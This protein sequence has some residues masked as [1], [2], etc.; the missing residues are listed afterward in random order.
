MNKRTA[1]IV[2]LIS[3]MLIFCLAGCSEDGAPV[4]NGDPNNELKIEF[5]RTV[6]D[7]SECRES[8]AVKVTNTSELA[9]TDVMLDVIPY[10]ADGNI[11]EFGEDDPGTED[12]RIGK[13]T[14]TLSIDCIMPGE[15]TG[16]FD[17]GFYELKNV[18]DHID[19]QLMSVSWRDPDKIEGGDVI[20]EDYSYSIGSEEICLTLK[21]ET[22]YDYDINDPLGKHTLNVIIIAFDEDDNITGGTFA[23][24]NARLD[25][26]DEVT[27][28]EYVDAEYIRGIPAARVEVYL[29]R[30][31]VRDDA[32]VTYFDDEGNELTEEEYLR[33]LE[34]KEQ[35]Q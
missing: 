5:G 9:A 7:S 25:A 32:Q 33:Y 34:D 11:I 3:A 12:G 29:E 14:N 17:F 18:P 27:T 35:D 26:G 30:Y 6:I 24:V 8:I 19:V 21:N 22:D 13:A 1:L 16:C 31:D 4:N 23:S 28:A 15:T 2:T 20:L 10:D